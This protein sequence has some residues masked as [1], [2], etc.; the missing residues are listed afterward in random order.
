MSLECLRL[1]V[2]ICAKYV[3]MYVCMYVGAQ[4]VFTV[5]SKRLDLVVGLG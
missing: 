1:C 4:E 5:S 2:C 3:C